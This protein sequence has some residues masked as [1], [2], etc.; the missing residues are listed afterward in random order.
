MKEVLRKIGLVVNWF[1][2]G[3]TGILFACAGLFLDGTQDEFN[4]GF[5]VALIV[6]ALIL[7]KVI[8]W[9]FE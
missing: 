4:L 8:N 6:I 1:L 5:G 9:I 7:H 3:G 2:L